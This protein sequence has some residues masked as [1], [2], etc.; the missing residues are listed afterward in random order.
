M[1]LKESE[2]WWPSRVAL[3]VVCAHTHLQMST[4]RLECK[5]WPKVTQLV[6]G[7]L[8]VHI[9]TRHFWKLVLSL[10]GMRSGPLVRRPECV[11]CPLA[12]QGLVSGLNVATPLKFMWLS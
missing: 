8:G 9:C 11:V 6:S 4:L 2:E 7:G 5:D 1:S 10:L 3:W 12:G